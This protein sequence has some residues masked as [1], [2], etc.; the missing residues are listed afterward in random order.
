MDEYGVAASV[1][2]VR[3]LLSRKARGQGPE[4][5]SRKSSAHAAPLIIHFQIIAHAHWGPGSHLTAPL[6]PTSQGC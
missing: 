1:F 2:S 5:R 3:G 4:F 6:L